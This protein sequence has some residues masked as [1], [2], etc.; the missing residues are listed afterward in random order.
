MTG[1]TAF[2]TVRTFL[3]AAAGCLA[4][5]SASIP[6]L[7]LPA[8]KAAAF[9][10]LVAVA[11]TVLTFT[12][13]FLEELGKIPSLFKEAPAKL[14]ES[15]A[16]ATLAALKDSGVDLAYLAR[17]PGELVSALKAAGL[18][19]VAPPPPSVTPTPPNARS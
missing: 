2:A 13:N 3:Q 18:L 4:M 12:Q 5:A 16:E 19:V 14:A 7:H 8:T 6:M 10:V 17:L 15:I 9:G 11:I 1:R